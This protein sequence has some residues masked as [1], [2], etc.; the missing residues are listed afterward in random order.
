MLQLARTSTAAGAV[1]ETRQL[2]SRAAKDRGPHA[3]T[4]KLERPS[5]KVTKPRLSCLRARPW[6]RTKQ[7]KH[8]VQSRRHR[9][10]ARQT[11]TRR[12]RGD[13]AASGCTTAPPSPLP[14]VDTL[15]QGPG[16]VQSPHASAPASGVQ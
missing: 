7:A 13:F 9:L 3:G 4:A 11:S 8:V 15:R 6:V 1:V 12:T 14:A 5:L 10:C 2:G 16:G